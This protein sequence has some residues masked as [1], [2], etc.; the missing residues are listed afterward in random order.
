[1]Q[2]EQLVGLGVGR[3]LDADGVLDARHEVDVGAVE[4]AGPLPDP[5]EVRRRVVGQTGARVDP[6]HRPLVV[7]HQRLVRREELD[8]AHRVEVG[9]ARGHELHRHVDVVGQLVVLL[10]R[11]VGDEA[12]VPVVH[13]AQVGEAAHGEGADEV[14]RRRGRV[15]GPD[16]PVRVGGAGRRLEGE[17]VDHVA[18]VCGQLDPVAGLGARAARLRVLTAHPAHLDDRDRGAVGE[19]RGHLEDRLDPVADVVGGRRHERLRAVTALQHERLTAR[20]RRHPVAQQVAL[21]SEDQAAGMT[22]SVSTA[23]R[24]AAASGQDGCWPATREAAEASSSAWSSALSFTVTPR[25]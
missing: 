7:E 9:P 18:P 17:V 11:G 23:V 22:D 25:F 14:Q 3:H 16:Q 6:G 20:R 21:P 24:T 12:L 15:V 2:L 19:H 4:V 5:D 13:V 8:R 10:V 1:M